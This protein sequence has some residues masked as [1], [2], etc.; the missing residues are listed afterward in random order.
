MPSRATWGGGA[1]G[2]GSSSK[3]DS[4]TPDA[5]P[6]PRGA[7]D[8]G[9]TATAGGRWALVSSVPGLPAAVAGSAGPRDVLR[10]LSV[11]SWDACLGPAWVDRRR[12]GV[13]CAESAE[14]PNPAPQW[15]TEQVHPALEYPLQLSTDTGASQRRIFVPSSATSC[16]Q[17]PTDMYRH[18]QAPTGTHRHAGAPTEVA[19]DAL[20]ADAMRRAN[21]TLR[22]TSTASMPA[23]RP[24]QATRTIATSQVRARWGPLPT[25]ATPDWNAMPAKGMR[26]CVSTDSTHSC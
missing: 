13:V 6:R 18:P 21:C 2:A 25:S 11:Q 1:G 23:N 26:V 5:L 15:H 22:H 14:K 10:G 17:L 20:L 7:S 16:P 9:S 19:E 24:M 3:G 8:T 4:D 12:P